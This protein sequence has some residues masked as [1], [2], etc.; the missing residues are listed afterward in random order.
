[1]TGG[2]NY[3]ILY[4]SVVMYVW[5]SGVHTI[6]CVLGTPIPKVLWLDMIISIV[7]SRLILARPAGFLESA[8]GRSATAITG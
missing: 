5:I 2:M 3:T 4:N 8:G 1:M 7:L 6:I